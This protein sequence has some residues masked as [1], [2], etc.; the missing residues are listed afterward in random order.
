MYATPVD[1]LELITVSGEKAK[2]F[3]G[4]YYEFI[5][6]PPELAISGQKEGEVIVLKGEDK[7]IFV[8]PLFQATFNLDQIKLRF[9][10]GSELLDSE[11]VKL[12]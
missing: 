2:L 1:E 11:R 6:Q 9:D 5:I 12:N 4:E 8:I 10:Q 3:L 7:F